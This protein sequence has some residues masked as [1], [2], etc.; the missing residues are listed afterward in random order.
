MRIVNA[1]PLVGFLSLA[2]LSLATNP[3]GTYGCATLKKDIPNSLFERNSTVY[4][5]ESNNFWSN[6]EI[7]SP[8]CV[9]RPE[10]ATELGTAIKLLKG[11]NTQFAVR[12]GGHMGIRVRIPMQIARNEANAHQIGLE[13]H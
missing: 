11:T 1:A 2:G 6:T 5:D 3:N 12:G 10:S 8:E 4:N 13:Q 9:F 7:M